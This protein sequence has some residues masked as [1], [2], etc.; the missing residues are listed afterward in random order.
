MDTNNNKHTRRKRGRPRSASGGFSLKVIPR[1]TPDAQKLG[2]ALLSLALHQAQQKG[3]S[4]QNL[5]EVS[6]E[7]Q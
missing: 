5:G 4:T 6:R 3:S 1:E 2:R 7:R